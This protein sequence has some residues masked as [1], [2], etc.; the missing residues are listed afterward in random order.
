MV[1]EVYVQSQKQLAALSSD[2][3]R[4][5]DIL[6]DLIVQVGAAANND[7]S[8]AYHLISCRPLYLSDSFG[9]GGSG[10]CLQGL[11]RLLEPE[12][13][14]RCREVD[15]PVVESVL[16]AAAA[17]YSKILHDEANLNKA[18]K[19]SIDKLGR[20]LPPPPSSDSNTPSW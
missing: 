5:K 19:L 14:I 4:Y 1:N 13:V 11:L 2:P 3:A 9:C 7:Q 12:V 17:K 18:V 15:R 10:V 16:P 8:R 6:T 20:Y